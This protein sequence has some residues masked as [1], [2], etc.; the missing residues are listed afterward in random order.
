MKTKVDVG[1]S[2]NRGTSVGIKNMSKTF[3]IADHDAPIELTRKN[4]PL[5]VQVQGVGYKILGDD[6]PEPVQDGMSWID[7][8]IYL[9][10]YNGA[11]NKTQLLSSGVTHIINATKE[12]PN[13]F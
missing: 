8:N 9:G 6:H 11:S 5:Q 2:T 12:I 10:D 4:T 13:Y 1:S 3:G 7:D